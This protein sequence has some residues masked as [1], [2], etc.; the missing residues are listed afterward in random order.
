MNWNNAEVVHTDCVVFF[1]VKEEWGGLS[2]MNNDYPL[3]VKGIRIGSSEALY[4]AMRYPHRPDW[5]REILGAP[6]AMQAK[7][8]SKKDGRRKHGTRPDWDTIQVDVM[9]WVLR[10]KLGC[11]ERVFGRLLLATGERA[12]VERSRKDRFWGA[13]LDEEVLHGENRLGQLLME[14]RDDFRRTKQSPAI[15]PPAVRSFR[16]LDHDLA[17]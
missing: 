14:L 9:R 16:L 6:G 10:V 12:I 8:K 4:Q 5:Q 11:H 7:M 13:V 3:L 1:K 17:A 15:T 2:N